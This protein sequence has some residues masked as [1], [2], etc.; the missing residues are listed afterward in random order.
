VADDVLKVVDGDSVA[1]EWGYTD[2]EAQ[3][4]VQYLEEKELVTRH[5]VVSRKVALKRYFTKSFTYCLRLSTKSWAISSFVTFDM[6]K[7][8]PLFSC[9]LIPSISPNVVTE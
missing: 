8:C 1:K 6:L 3:S 7:G 5:G 4:I 9:G 2:D